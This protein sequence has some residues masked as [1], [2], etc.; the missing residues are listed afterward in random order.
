MLGFTNMDQYAWLEHASFWKQFSK[1]APE[2]AL[3]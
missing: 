2:L 3:H 1:E